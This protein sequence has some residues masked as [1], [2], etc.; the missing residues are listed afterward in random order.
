M[1]SMTARLTLLGLIGALLLATTAGGVAA[2]IALG[3]ADSKP[4]DE[5]LMRLS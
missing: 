1:G 3:A 2:Q 5:R 4:Y